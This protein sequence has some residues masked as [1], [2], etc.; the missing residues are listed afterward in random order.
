MKLKAVVAAV[1][2]LAAGGAMAC[3]GETLT[4]SGGSA[5]FNGGTATG[6]FSDTFCFTV[7]GSLPSVVGAT[8]VNV[9][10]QITIP[11]GGS[12]TI[13]A[14]A[15]FAGSLNG[16]PLSFTQFV[17]GGV[18]SLVLSTSTI[19]AAESINTLIFT[20]TSAG[21]YAGAITVTAVP[22][23]GTIALMLAG[24]G[25]VGFLAKRRGVIGGQPMAV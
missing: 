20:G 17:S 3:T 23:P 14:I 13:P 16:N 5:A 6:A 21:S 4:F 12:I 18:T 11:F 8:A 19:L 15:N 2:M 25:V 24:L 7:P 9:G 10:Y 22:E 1:A